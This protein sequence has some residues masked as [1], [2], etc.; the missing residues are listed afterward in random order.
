MPAPFTKEDVEA[1]V[2]AYIHDN[3]TS[4]VNHLIQH[5]LTELKGSTT[6]YKILVSATL[7]SQ[8]MGSLDGKHSVGFLWNEET[9]G[10]Y[11]I[12]FETGE[13]WLLVSVSYVKM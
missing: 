6:D 12:K 3:D 11:A 5:V 10:H 13:S 4:D 2:K 7:L 8:H 1:L 9:D